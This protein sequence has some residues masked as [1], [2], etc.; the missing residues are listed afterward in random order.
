M[1]CNIEIIMHQCHL[2]SLIMSAGSLEYQKTVIISSV[3]L[4]L[5]R[6]RSHFFQ[7]KIILR[8]IMQNSPLYFECL[9]CI[10]YMV[11][12]R[13]LLGSLFI[14]VE[15]CI[16]HRRTPVRFI[17]VTIFV[18]LIIYIQKPSCYEKGA[19]W[20]SVPYSSKNALCS[21]LETATGFLIQ[22]IAPFVLLV[23][24]GIETFF[25]IKWSIQQR[26]TN[27][28]SVVFIAATRSAMTNDQR[29]SSFLSRL[30][31]LMYFDE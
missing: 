31:R 13:F 28:S 29:I 30:W 12:G 5:S 4:F 1:G 23:Y 16:S 10:F 3:V 2:P 24:F 19:T 14:I 25:N 26:R 17:F 7:Q 11:Y 22:F 6:G 21:I 18:V 9:Y 20:T 15:W 8:W 27:I